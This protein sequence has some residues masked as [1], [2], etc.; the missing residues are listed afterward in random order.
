MISKKGFS[1]R[2]FLKASALGMIGSGTI[3]RSKFLNARE[4]EA[5]EA[6]K[7]KEYR[8]LGRTGFKA[9]DIS[10][11][12]TTDVALLNALLD[13]GINYIDTSESY[14][15]GRI[16]ETVGE[17]IK[18][19]N[20]KSFFITTKT[21]DHSESRKLSKED[22]TKEGFLRRIRKSLERLQTDYIDCIMFADPMDSNSIKQEGFHAAVKQLKEEG[23]VKYIGISH[24]GSE[25]QEG[26]KE[27]ME[28]ILLAAAEDGRYDVM[29]L[30]YSFLNQDMGER[31]MRVCRE[32]KI[33]TT[34]M[35]IE[36]AKLYYGAKQYI[37]N[38]EKE[39]K[40]VGD[41]LRKTL[42][43][44]KE[45]IDGA[46]EFYNK[47]NLKT[48]ADIRDAS[49]RFVLSNP[50]V[51][52]A[53]ISFKN[54]NDLKD[55]VKL[56]GSRLTAKDQALLSAYSLNCG[57]LYCRHACGLC[58]SECPHKVPVNAI[59][60]YDHYF[61]AQGR[62]KFAMNKYAALPK[63]KAD[64]C[65]SCDGPCQKACPYGVPVQGLLI[66]AHQVMTLV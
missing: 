57:S 11:G 9:S 66:H 34:L 61:E 54:Y 20:R 65:L 33:G 5:S 28:E 60:R 8:T 45:Q 26:R 17:V 22:L 30:V 56:S 7:I 23:R 50:D 25:W 15:G 21:S 55:Y 13:S 16:E 2:K 44:L 63:A 49:I 62:E 3:G 32:K 47:Y 46:Q 18:N 64:T 31:V 52:T 40:E 10:A 29:L 36:P 35:K 58:E 24:H 38:L 42:S 51:N 59:M 12:V 41:R 48:P 14:A 37:E 4:Q 53:C 19:R 6:P 39:G 43:E 1:R 27:T